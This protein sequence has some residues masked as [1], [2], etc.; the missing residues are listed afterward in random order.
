MGDGHFSQV[1]KHGPLQG[2]LLAIVTEASNI[3]ACRVGNTAKAQRPGREGSPNRGHPLG[4]PLLGKTPLKEAQGMRLQS[5][6]SHGASGHF[7]LVF[8]LPIFLVN[9]PLSPQDTLPGA[10]HQPEDC[11]LPP[12]STHEDW[13]VEWPPLAPSSPSFPSQAQRGRFCRLLLIQ[14]EEISYGNSDFS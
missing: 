7:H 4:Q 3:G 8:S 14:R 13:L 9:G 6:L 12:P 2:P 5:N 11:F 1:I 10:W